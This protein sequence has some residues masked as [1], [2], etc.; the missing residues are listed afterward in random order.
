[1]PRNGWYPV[2][3]LLDPTKRSISLSIVSR[4]AR[5]IGRPKFGRLTS[6]RLSAIFLRAS[7][8]VATS[9]RF[10]HP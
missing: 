7:I 1:M 5:S 6:K 10:Q 4:T 2:L 9:Y 3:S 8:I